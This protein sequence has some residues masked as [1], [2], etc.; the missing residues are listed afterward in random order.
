MSSS[1]F[2]VYFVTLS[3]MSILVANEFYRATEPTQFW[4]V[5]HI[6]TAISRHVSTR[7]VRLSSPWILAVSSLSN[8]TAR[9]DGRDAQL[10]VLC[11]LCSV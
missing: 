6:H 11:N 7:H 3:C 2:F 1:L 10:S 8:S 5:V 4:L 9:H